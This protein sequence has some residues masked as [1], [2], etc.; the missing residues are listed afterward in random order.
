MTPIQPTIR[1]GFSPTPAQRQH[2]VP[3]QQTSQPNDSFVR[4]GG[5][6]EPD[7]SDNNRIDKLFSRLSPAE[8]LTLIDELVLGALDNGDCHG[9][10]Q[11]LAM[12]DNILGGS[13]EELMEKSGDEEMPHIDIEAILKLRDERDAQQ[14]QADADWASVLLDCDL[15][16]AEEITSTGKSLRDEQGDLDCRLC[17]LMA[18]VEDALRAYE[19]EQALTLYAEQQDVQAQR[20]ALGYDND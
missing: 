15:V 9:A 6:S 2:G 20:D 1:F 4:F 14:N 17:E 8:A 18:A 13:P 19:D 3:L 7:N 12:R 5:A 16:D 11:F 10:R